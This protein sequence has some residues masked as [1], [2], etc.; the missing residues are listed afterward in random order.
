MKARKW[1]LVH[2]SCHYAPLCFYRLS[3]VT[4][5]A[6]ARNHERERQGMSAYRQVCDQRG[7]DVT[8][9]LAVSPFN[10]LMFHSAYIGGMNA[11][12]LNDFRGLDEAKIYTPTGRVSSFTTVR[13]HIEIQPS[14]WP[15]PT[16]VLKLSNKFSSFY[17]TESLHSLKTRGKGT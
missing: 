3:A 14:P 16:R 2:Q 10:G 17:L 13:E 12:R 6:V 7:W 15:I 5:S 9:V 11:P 1:K 4:T 8:V